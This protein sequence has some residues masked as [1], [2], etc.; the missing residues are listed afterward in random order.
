MVNYVGEFLTEMEY[1]SLLCS[2]SGTH[3]CRMAS[4]F[5]SVYMTENCPI[6][7]QR[8]KGSSPRDTL[9]VTF[10]IDEFQCSLLGNGNKNA[11]ALF[12]LQFYWP[13]RQMRYSML[14]NNRGKVYNNNKFGHVE[15]DF[16]DGLS[17]GDT[18]SFSVDRN[19]AGFVGVAINGAGYQSME[20][21]RILPLD[22]SGGDLLIY[23]MCY[24]WVP[25]TS[26]NMSCSC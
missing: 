4:R 23:A 6:F 14:I 10:S 20:T 22:R 17:A 11:M 1:S 16:G 3:L 13:K 24:C 18:L 19:G 9:H 7:R 21:S 12:G 2:Y 5:L 26:K 15:I 8:L 25:R